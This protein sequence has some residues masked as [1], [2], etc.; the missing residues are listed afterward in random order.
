LGYDSNSRAYHVFN[1]ITGCVETTCDTIFD[2]INNSQKEQIDLDLVDDEEAPCDALQRMV[3]D[4]ISPQDTSDQSHKSLIKIIMKRKMDTMSQMTPLHMLESI[5]ILLT[6]ATNNGFKLY[7]MDV[8]SAFLNGLIKKEVY[9]EQY[10]GFESEEYPNHV[11][12]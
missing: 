11:T 8:K 10:L 3:I 2:E 12:P 7:Q 6:Y 1:M 9:V 5:R 4:K